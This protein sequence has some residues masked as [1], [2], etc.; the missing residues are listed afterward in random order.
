[1]KTASNPIE[2]LFNRI[3]DS[4]TTWIGFKRLKPSPTE[5]M[6]ARTVLV[7]SLFYAPITAV[8]IVVG[9][10]FLG[11]RGLTLWIGFAVGA[12]GFILL[13]SLSAYFWNRRAS[14]IQFCNAKN[15]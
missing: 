8:A 14:R 2:N 9:F 1:M 10:Y 15:S 13:Q 3:N 7:L 6:S 11:L 4:D 12:V 5:R